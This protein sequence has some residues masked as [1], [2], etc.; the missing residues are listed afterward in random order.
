MEEKLILSA[1]SADSQSRKGPI[2]IF[3]WAK[4]ALFESLRQKLIS[5]S[6]VKL[7]IQ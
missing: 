5:L 3:N 7:S 1:P 4:E 6:F 2:S